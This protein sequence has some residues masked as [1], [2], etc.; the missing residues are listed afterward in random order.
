[1]LPV[2]SGFIQQFLAGPNASYINSQNATFKPSPLTATFSN[3]GQVSQFISSLGIFDDVAPLPS[4]S[5]PLFQ[6]YSASNFNTMRGTATLERMTCRVPVTG[7][8]NATTTTSQFVR[9]LLNDAVYP[10]VGCASG[11][12]ATCPLLQYAGIVANKTVQ[13]GTLRS[14]CRLNA[15]VPVID[16]ATFM[17]D[18]AL[19]AQIVVKP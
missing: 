11:P 18:D 14:R 10:V 16:V 3:D 12:G 1:M 6:K 4:T 13:A 17:R 15:T 9:V 5:I 19:S 7:A 8:G 2:L